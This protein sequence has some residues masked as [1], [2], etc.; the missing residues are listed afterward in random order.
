[1]HRP[2]EVS[3]QI[4]RGRWLIQHL[5]L[6]SAWAQGVDV[7]TSYA[8]DAVHACTQGLAE[9][10]VDDIIHASHGLCGDL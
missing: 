8:D 4:K 6:P 10:Y 5:K 9:S 3:V 1:M 2:G 7:A